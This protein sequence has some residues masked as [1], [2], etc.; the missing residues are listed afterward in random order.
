MGGCGFIVPEVFQRK[1]GVST[2]DLWTVSGG[3][4]IQSPEEI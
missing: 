1:S 4:G 2:L 3:V